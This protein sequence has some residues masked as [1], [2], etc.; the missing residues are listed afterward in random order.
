MKTVKKSPTATNAE[1]RE[2]ADK[3]AASELAGACN[4]LTKADGSHESSH[5]Q[6]PGKHR[7]AVHTGDP[8]ELRKGEKE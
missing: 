8:S 3:R 7:K 4:K 5:K 6:I 2:A 1:K